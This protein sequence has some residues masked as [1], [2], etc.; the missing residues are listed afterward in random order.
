MKKLLI[1]II[2]SVSAASFIHAQT[3][4]QFKAMPPQQRAALFADT[5]KTILHLNSFQFGKIYGIALDAAQKA[6]PIMQSDKSRLSK[7][8]EVKPIF[9]TAEAKIKSVLTPDQCTLYEAKK[10]DVIAYYRQKFANR[11]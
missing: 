1:I 4:E 6:S 2:I 7:A 5:L 9:S 10:Q 8:Q 11:Q 3:P